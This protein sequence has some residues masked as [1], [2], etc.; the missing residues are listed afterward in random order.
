M[1]RSSGSSARRQTS[2]LASLSPVTCSVIHCAARSK[3]GFCL[4]SMS[5]VTSMVKVFMASSQTTTGS[6]RG[7][8]TRSLSAST[9]TLSPDRSFSPCTTSPVR[10][11]RAPPDRNEEST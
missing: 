7:S 6:P 8:S 4:V 5:A 1:A 2:M 9:I 10:K 11:P 3:V